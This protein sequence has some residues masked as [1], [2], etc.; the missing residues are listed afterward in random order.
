[1]QE[2]HNTCHAKCDPGYIVVGGGCEAQ[3][4]W[5]LS[6]SW[7]LENGWFCE[8][9]EDWGSKTYDKEVVGYAIC[10]RFNVDDATP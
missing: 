8:G 3:S 7:P 1:M 4:G 2:R 6:R 5:R 9:G 10:M